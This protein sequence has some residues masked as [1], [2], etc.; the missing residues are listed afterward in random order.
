[1]VHPFQEVF[2]TF[3]LFF[4]RTKVYSL[5]V[6]PDWQQQNA[7]AAILKLGHSRKR[8]DQ[9]AAQVLG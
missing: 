5:T 2:F 1:M 8:N 7:I 3:Q 9:F 4:A 6:P